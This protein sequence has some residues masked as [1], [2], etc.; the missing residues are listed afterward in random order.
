ME[1][2]H[3]CNSTM[4]KINKFSCGFPFYYQLNNLIFTTTPNLISFFSYYYL[5]IVNPNSCFSTND[6]NFYRNAIYL[7]KANNG[8][9]IFVLVKSSPS[10][11][12]SVYIN[13]HSHPIMFSDKAT[14]LN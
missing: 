8:D 9:T 11:I 14:F 6:N 4:R 1:K 5:I 7:V 10:A 12:I 3:C 13:T 2:S